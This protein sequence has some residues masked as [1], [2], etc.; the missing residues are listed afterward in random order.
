MGE[1][2]IHSDQDK[3]LVKSDSFMSDSGAYIA[4]PNTVFNDIS[5]VFL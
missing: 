5:S 3:R 4:I 1:K 2:V